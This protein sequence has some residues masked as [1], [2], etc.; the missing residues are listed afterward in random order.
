MTFQIRS[1]IIQELIV[2]DSRLCISITKR[3]HCYSGDAGC[4]AAKREVIYYL[5]KRKTQPPQAR[6]GTRDGSVPIWQKG[7][8]PTA[9]HVSNSMLTSE[10]QQF[11]MLFRKQ[12]DFMVFL[13]ENFCKY[14][15]EVYDLFWLG[16]RLQD[17]STN[18]QM[19][20]QDNNWS[21][22]R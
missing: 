15:G 1:I 6:P 3:F 7:A 16:K 14:Y 22:Y 9:K 20:K 5:L 2:M 11:M 21:S 17:K 18:Y 10:L 12:G 19:P 13:M 4:L 8:M